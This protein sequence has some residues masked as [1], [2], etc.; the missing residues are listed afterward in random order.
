MI[1]FLIIVGCFFGLGLV[2]GLVFCIIRYAIPGLIWA[3]SEF[4]KT[5]RTSWAEGQLEANQ[6]FR[7]RDEQQ[8]RE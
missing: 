8:P 7:N 4:V 5:V 2:I 1:T 3:I 6:Y